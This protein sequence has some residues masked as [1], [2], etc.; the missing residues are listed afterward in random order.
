[1]AT[2]LGALAEEGIGTVGV[3]V[4]EVAGAW[5]RVGSK[6]KKDGRLE[7]A[8][9]VEEEEV[10][11]AELLESASKFFAER[12]ILFLGFFPPESYPF[13]S[14]IYLIFFLEARRQISRSRHTRR[15]HTSWRRRHEDG[16]VAEASRRKSNSLFLLL[17]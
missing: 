7:E 10:M 15:R 5:W 3:V 14:L 6:G 4:V 8:E 9:E 13:S 11:E 12:C 16:R 17:R 1:M 2:S